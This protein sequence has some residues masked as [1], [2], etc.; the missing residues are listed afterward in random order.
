MKKKKSNSLI[1]KML[2][3]SPDTVSKIE[4]EKNLIPTEQEKESE[5]DKEEAVVTPPIENKP[6]TP[7]KPEKETPEEKVIPSFDEV[8]AGIREALSDPA[9]DRERKE[10]VS[11]I[12]SLASTWSDKASN[13]ADSAAKKSDEIYSL[14]SSL[15]I[16]Q[17]K[18]YDEL[19]DFIKSGDYLSTPAAQ[20]ILSSYLRAA[21]VASDNE[22]ASSAGDN[23]GNPDSYGAAN[24]HRQRL[25]YTDA[26]NDAALDFYERQADRLAELIATSGDGLAGIYSQMQDNADSDSDFA[27]ES[28]SSVRGALSDLL[29]SETDEQKLEYDAIAKLYDKYV[30]EEKEEEE[31]AEPTSSMSPMGID[32]EYDRLKR[33]GVSGTDALIT[34]WNAYPE[35]RDY[36]AD[37]Y[38]DILRGENMYVFTE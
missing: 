2:G 38:E 18:S 16:S 32:K 4:G 19:S 33:K 7:S 12:K 10:T 1:G 21:G 6:E 20:S 11:S 23:S 34:L 37:K 28:L 31:P 14:L 30:G 25:A 29:A 26:A 5:K 36:I 8:V 35:M 27:L 13:R 24:A 22:T 15:G 9:L 3:I 17:K